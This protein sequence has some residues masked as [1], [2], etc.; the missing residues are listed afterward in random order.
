MRMEHR[1]VDYKVSNKSWA[2]W[3]VSIA[4]QILHLGQFNQDQQI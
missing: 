3:T 4:V 2:L 1:I